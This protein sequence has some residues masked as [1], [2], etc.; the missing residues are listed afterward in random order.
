MTLKVWRIPH[1]LG[2][3]SSPSDDMVAGGWPDAV[4]WVGRLRITAAM[5]NNGN[6]R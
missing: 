1:F 3:A 2:C 4:E 5:P 6:D